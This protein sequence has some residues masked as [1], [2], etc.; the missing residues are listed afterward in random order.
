MLL[1][2]Y[3]LR[4]LRMHHLLSFLLEFTHTSK[5]HIVH[6]SLTKHLPPN[7]FSKVHLNNLGSQKQFGNQNNLVRHP[8]KLNGTYENPGRPFESH[9]DARS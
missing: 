2:P 3:L 8:V 9:R 6:C 5:L 4:S 7:F 1:E